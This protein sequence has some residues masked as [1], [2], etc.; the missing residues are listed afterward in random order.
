MTIVNHA[1]WA[2]RLSKR[3][4]SAFVGRVV[5]RSLFRETLHHRRLPFQALLITGPPGTGKTTLLR[6]FGSECEHAGVSHILV[7]ARAMQPS[8]DS[9]VRSLRAA[10]ALDEGESITGELALHPRFVLMI[11]NYDRLY[12]L[13]DWLC[14]SLYPELPAST[15]VVVASRKP[16]PDLWATDPAWRELVRTVSLG[17]FSPDET[18]AYLKLRE[19][20]PDQHERITRFSHGHPLALSLLADLYHQQS[21]PEFD[22]S[23]APNVMQ[24]LVRRFVGCN[25]SLSPVGFGGL[26]HRPGDDRK[27]PRG[28]ARQSGRQRGV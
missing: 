4:T 9:F 5:E 25:R 11:D 3:R 7:D 28:D 2:Q 10:L 27:H 16:P 12:A 21:E 23:T 15:L 6:I 24:T 26:R 17:N 18:R 19:V 8:P 14:E 1:N 13:H 20:P 22:P